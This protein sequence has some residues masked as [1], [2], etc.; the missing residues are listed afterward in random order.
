MRLF[1]LLKKLGFDRLSRRD[2]GKSGERIAVKFLKRKGFKILERNVRLS[3]KEFDI[4]AMDNE[5]LVFV[6]VKTAASDSYGHPSEWISP[7]KRKHLINGARLYLNRNKIENTPVRFDVVTI[8]FDKGNY[9]IGYLPDAF[10]A[11]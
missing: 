4:I 7:Y 6:E 8:V 2:I 9:E 3:F 11:D 1:G 5:Y 10:S